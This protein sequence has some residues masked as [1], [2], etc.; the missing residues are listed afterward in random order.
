MKK[1]VIK[2]L[3][4]EDNP[5]DVLFWQESLQKDPLS[6]FQLIVVECLK[7]G[8][9]ELQQGPFDVVLLDLDLPDSQGQDTFR[10]LQAEFPAIPVLVLSEVLDETAALELVK[11]GAQDYLFK[12]E[13]SK[14]LGPRAIRYAFERH[15]LQMAARAT[16]TA[17][18]RTETLLAQAGQ[19]AHLGAWTIEINQPNDLSANPL[20]WSDEV[21]RIFG[22][23]PGAVEVTNE[24]FFAHVHPDDRLV[25]AETIN[26]SLREKKPYKVEHRVI[27]PDGSERIVLEYADIIF[28]V[29]DTPMCVL[30]AVKDI[31]ERKQV[32]DALR[33]GEQRYRTLFQDSPIPIWEE[34]YSQLKKHLNSLQQQG[35]T[36]FRTYFLEHP[37]AILE[38][39]LLIKIVDVN[40]AALRMYKANSREELFNSTFETLSQ[41]EQEH[42]YEDFIAIAEGKSSHTWEGGD[43]TMTGEPLEISLSWSLVP[44]HEDDYSKVIL[45]TL[46]ITEHK[47]TEA[48]LR[49]SEEHLRI[50]IE[51]ANLAVWTY[52]P[53]TNTLLNLASTSTWQGPRIGSLMGMIEM[54]HQD[55]VASVTKA[56]QEALITGQPYTVESRMIQADGRLS[57]FVSQGRLITRP[58]GPAQLFG[59]SLDITER[60]QA[61]L[62]LKQVESRYRALTEN[63]PDGIAMVSVDGRFLYVSPSSQ[64]IFGY[65]FDEI[66]QFS[67]SA[68]TH[69]DDLPLVLNLLDNL[70]KN[71]HH[72]PMLQYRFLHK[73]KGWRWI[74]STFSNLLAEPSVAAIVI[75]FRDISERKQMEQALAEEHNLLAQRVEERT[76]ELSFAN[77]ALAR[78]A[79]MKDEFLASMSHELRTP[80]TAILGLS[81]SLQEFVYGALNVEQLKSLNIIETSGRHL[82]RLINDILDLSKIEAGKLDLEIDI[83]QVESVC[84]LSLQMVR[85]L[86]EKKQ[87]QVSYMRVE[88]LDW[89]VGDERRLK[90]MLVNLLG[91]AIKFTAEGG[92]IGLAVTKELNED[93]LRFTVWDTGI[94]IS[95]DQLDKLFKP[96]VQLDS[97]LSRQ[98]TGTG[99]GLALVR[100]LAELHRGRVGVESE[101][102]KGSRFY[103]II[104]T[105]SLPSRKGHLSVKPLSQSSKSAPTKSGISASTPD[106][107]TRPRLLVVEDNETNLQILTD[108]LGAQGYGVIAAADGFLALELAQESPPDLILMDIQ[109]PGMDGFETIRRLRGLPG[110]VSTPI[111]AITALA[112]SG[113]PERCLAAGANGYLSKPL[114]LP[115]LRE[116][117]IQLSRDKHQE[118]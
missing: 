73:D 62:A 113:D 2:V 106:Y 99:L 66:T 55:D 29:D 51:A 116:M 89:I 20:F 9:A 115:L 25:V 54:I 84:Q 37:E 77:A 8:L 44:G 18:R 79:R 74:E 19:I 94:G 90:Q 12:G 3:L 53:E 4:I 91:N 45:T 26:R 86:A 41:G 82:L 93:A 72:T 47:R 75:N 112:M 58:Q 52:D 92:W 46:D 57:Y 70:I 110:L 21:Y 48:K 13:M 83:V 15:Q 23:E 36:D 67:P 39:S 88:T 114:H 42:L 30:G 111:I 96:F 11:S 81:E 61:E 35:V 63:A 17:L 40:N 68:M 107:Q 64:R 38:C 16:E 102:G 60:K 56:L 108:Y 59:V 43:E 117:I 97:T 98:Y 105:P 28:A 101:P 33:E 69:P 34:D 6:E 78:A 22:Y 27:R 7:Q 118:E 50:A 95:A 49:E 14:S 71:P 31:T 24:L 80:L 109:L 103:F 5:A 104:P 65:F 87:I 76:A 85:Q 32:E 100:Q 10:Q 1:T